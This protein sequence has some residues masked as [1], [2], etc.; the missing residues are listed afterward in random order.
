MLTV[1][2]SFGRHDNDYYDDSSCFSCFPYCFVK[3]IYLKVWIME[4]TA[5]D[6]IVHM[7]KNQIGSMI[8]YFMNNVL[9]WRQ[10]ALYVRLLREAYVINYTTKYEQ[11]FTHLKKNSNF[12]I[13][14]FPCTCRRAWFNCATVLCGHQLRAQCEIIAKLSDKQLHF[15]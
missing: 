6:E 2:S 8:V 12:G 5:T 10:L 7:C 4:G 9:H 15:L 3:I 14:F 1:F 11:G 13:S